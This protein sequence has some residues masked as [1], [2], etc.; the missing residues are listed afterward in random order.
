MP[1]KQTTKTTIDRRRLQSRN[2]QRRYREET[3]THL[4]SLEADV[5]HLQHSSFRLEGQVEMLHETIA[6]MPSPYL[7][8]INRVRSYWTLF[9][10]GYAKDNPQLE[11][12]QI[13]MLHSLMEE[14][15]QISCKS[16]IQEVVR[17]WKYCASHYSNFEM[18]GDNFNAVKITDDEFIIRADG[19]ISL[20]LT[21]SSI[22]NLWPR[23]ISNLKLA[24]KLVGKVLVCPCTQFLNMRQNSLGGNKVYRCD[25]EWNLVDGLLKL[26]SRVEF[27]NLVLHGINVDL[28]EPSTVSSLAYYYHV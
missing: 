3:R 4:A 20:Q 5:R 21:L 17:Q 2:N 25:F 24:D 22:Q 1:T 10:S 9:S 12:S 13:E 27:V 15:V 6:A 19:R 14:N 28:F 26:L 23:L 7:N 8:D 11:A 18:V 16:G